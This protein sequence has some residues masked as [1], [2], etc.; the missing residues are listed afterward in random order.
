M[1]SCPLT[2]FCQVQNSLCVQVLRI[3]SV[4]TS[5][6]FSAIFITGRLP[7]ASVNHR[8]QSFSCC[9]RT[10]VERSAA[11]RNLRIL[12]VYFSQ[13]SE[14]SPLPAMLPLTVCVVP[15]QWLLSFSDT[16]IVRVTYLLTY[17]L[18]GTAFAQQ[19]STEGSTY[20]RRAAITLGIGPHSSWRTTS[21][22]KLR[23]TCADTYSVN[24]ERT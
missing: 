20:I 18:H 7:Y 8:R 11:A 10:R 5:P 12:S 15:E 6:S 1:G 4:T 14:D 19:H 9:R 23:R 21:L 13:T 22:R 2:E 24:L 17:L 16:L 3:G